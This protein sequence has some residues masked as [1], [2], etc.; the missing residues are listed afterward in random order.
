MKLSRFFCALLFVFFAT[1][2]IAQS[3]SFTNPDYFSTCNDAAFEISI[4]NNTSGDLQDITV[5]LSFPCEIK[6]VPSSISGATE[7]NISN[8]GQP[9]FNLANLPIGNTIVLS[10]MAHAPC[11]V[12]ACVDAGQLF[13]YSLDLDYAGGQLHNVSSGDFD[14][15]TSLLVFT[16]VNAP[17]LHGVKGQTLLRTFTVRNTRPGPIKS[18]VFTDSHPI[19]LNIKSNIGTDISTSGDELKVAFSGADF[20]NIGDGDEFLEQGEELIIT[21]QIQINICGQEQ[22]AA[23]SDI[24]LGWGCDAQ[25]CETFDFKAIVYIDVNTQLGNI[26][27]FDSVVVEPICY[28]SS[29]PLRESLTIT[30]FSPL[31]DASNVFIQFT[32]LPDGQYFLEHSVKMVANGDTSELA[33]IFE[34]PSN[35]ACIPS[36]DS[37]STMNFTVPHIPAG[38]SVTVF[39]DLEVCTEGICLSDG[40]SWAYTG[41]YNKDCTIPGDIYHLISSHNVQSISLVE[42]AIASLPLQ[43]N[44]TQ[45]IKYYVNS[46]FLDSL[47]GTMHINFNLPCGMSIQNPVDWSFNGV[48]PSMFDISTNGDNTEINLDYPL[49]MASPDGFVAV[50]VLFI[51]D[52]ICYSNEKPPK[53][54]LMSSCPSVCVGTAGCEK[55]TSG[56]VISATV[57][58]Q[59]DDNCNPSCNLKYCNAK[60]TN[61]GSGTSGVCIDTVPGYAA[62]SFDMYRTTYG[63]ADNDD[64]HLPDPAGNLNLNAIRT[65]RAIY[66]DSLHAHI[67]GVVITDIPDVAFPNGYIEF[68]ISADSSFG[69]QAN[70]KAQELK[71]LLDPNTG[72]QNYQSTFRIFDKSANTYYNCPVVPD[73]KAPE[74]SGQTLIYY[75]DISPTSLTASGGNVPTNFRYEKGDSILFDADYRINYNFNNGSA[76]GFFSLNVAPTIFLTDEPLPDRDKLFACNCQDQNMEIAN[77]TYFTQNGFSSFIDICEGET[78]DGGLLLP[79]YYGVFPNFFPNEYRKTATL[80]QLKIPKV[81]GLQLIESYIE[82]ATLNGQYILDYPDST[83]IDYSS[84][85]TNNIS[86]PN[87]DQEGYYIFNLSDFPELIWDDNVYVRMRFNYKNTGC[88]FNGKNNYLGQLSSDLLPDN[89]S[90]HTQ[91]DST[92]SIRLAGKEPVLNLDFELCNKLELSDSISWFFSISN[93]SNQS[94]P[95]DFV[96]DAPNVWLWPTTANGLVDNYHLFNQLTNQEIPIQNGIFQL[97]SLLQCDSIHLKLTATNHNC[98]PANVVFKY[99]WSCTPFTNPIETPCVSLEKTCQ[100]TSPPGVIDL[101]PDTIALSAA[102]CEEMPF[103]YLEVFDAGLGS[104]YDLKVNAQLPPGLIINT[105]TS[106]MEWPT[107][108]GNFVLVSDPIDLG[109]GLYQW[110]IT[111]ALDT[112]SHGLPG[113]NSAPANSVTLRFKTLTTCDFI[114]GSFII[115]AASAKKVCDLPTNT[116][117]KI[118]KPINITSISTPYTTAITLGSDGLPGCNDSLSIQVNLSFS[119][120]TKINDKLFAQLPP[121]TT[122]A[123]GSCSGDFPNCEPTISGN[124]LSWLLPTG[125]TAATLSFKIIGFLGQECQTVAIPFYATSQATALCVGTNQDC[126]IKIQ[127]GSQVA[128]I[129]IEKPIFSIQSFTAYPV[130]G[131]NNLVDLAINIQNVGILNTLPITAKLYFDNDGDGSISAGDTFI[132]SFSFNEFL[133]NGDATLLNILAQAIPPSDA[134]KLMIVIGEPENC[135]C[136]TTTL[137]IQVPILYPSTKIDTICSGATTVIGQPALA[138]HNYQ[139]EPNNGIDCLTCSETN[140]T[141]VNESFNAITHHLILKDNADCLVSFEYIIT[142]LPKPRIWSA[143]EQICQGDIA[144]LVASDGATYQ[145]QGEGITAPDQQIQMVSPMSDGLYTVTITNEKGCQNVDSV[146]VMVLANP[147]ADA[148]D[149]VSI[150]HGKTAQLN[151]NVD[152][153]LDIFWTPGFPNLDNPNIS[154]P[155]ILTDINATFTLTVSNGVCTATDEVN[156]NFFDGV[157]LTISQD[158]A[159]CLG[160][161]V[162][163]TVNGADTYLWT[164]SFPGMCQNTDCSTIQI[165]PTSSLHLT[166]KGMTAEGCTDTIGVNVTIIEDTLFTN[167]NLAICNG[168]STVIFGQTV[169]TAG[170]YCDTIEH[171]AGCYEVKCINVSLQDSIFVMDS[172]QICDGTTYML[173]NQVLTE[174]GT[175]CVDT[176]SSTGCDSTYCLN[177]TVLPSPAISINPSEGSI[178][179]GDS[180]QVEVVGNNI[181]TIWHPTEHLSC[182]ECQNPIASPTETTWF[183][184]NATDTNGCQTTDSILIK[185]ETLCDLDIEI[186]NA[187]TPNNDGIN[188]FFQVANLSSNLGNVQINVFSRWGQKV[189]SGKDNSGWDGKYKGKEMPADAYVY[190]IVLDCADREKKALKGDVILLR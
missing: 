160:D 167:T 26:L 175:Y 116:I 151:A 77:I 112:L 157:G 140:F 40:V 148:G 190:L 184:V 62:Y 44:Q 150:C 107:G 173:N 106:E 35:A 99:G 98:D 31:N 88:K 34:D 144:T 109:N 154:N 76:F 60:T 80:N 143:D 52:S 86:F 121:N 28:C 100:V 46:L 158:T 94:C 14:M 102:L 149:D 70:L 159:I 74:L 153:G 66:G 169:N 163:L 145:W 64:N 55:L 10:Y 133:N 101:V 43:D 47:S 189:F 134:C 85:E 89:Q 172:A 27:A 132:Q 114:S 131:N 104:I 6:Y 126:N 137:N 97:D 170:V 187:F 176:L 8:L 118:G 38:E 72:F 9:I 63:K 122:Y 178:K 56:A 51:K 127:T 180:L 87:E 4:T 92:V 83:V 105:G 5:Q 141:Q 165:A 124:E 136:A 182:I 111:E 36:K 68:R 115:Y 168:S 16:Q 20:V 166:V 171:A 117:A 50:P 119:D 67:Q 156:V 57:S 81:E 108:S 69:V 45:T 18:F 90:F 49:P 25:I 17:I 61:F 82:F 2:I 139:W 123:P 19:G 147:I 84:I 146:L 73:G 93:R 37:Y 39:W 142:V 15:T 91:I 12:S 129:D 177:L 125:V 65:D 78:K 42:G 59:L 135:V 32:P 11:A 58:L 95:N 48:A 128:T 13:N 41:S 130:A 3:I 186:P 183:Y 110:N 33:P 155:T 29:Q 181:T 7:G 152:S 174:S 138:G 30:N 164:P 75:Y 96:S 53:D 23:I 54:S 22:I 21:E 161:T 185:V 71:K 103:S 1:S 179:I 24:S 162:T 120:S 113:V 79:L 188:D